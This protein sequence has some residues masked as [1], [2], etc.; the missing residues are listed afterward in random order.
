[1]K[2]FKN[3]VAMDTGG[4]SGLGNAIANNVFLSKTSIDIIQYNDFLKLQ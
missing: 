3:K 4:S 1:M 2:D